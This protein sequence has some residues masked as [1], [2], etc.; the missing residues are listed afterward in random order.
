MK[1]RILILGAGFGGLAAATSLRSRLGPEHEIVVVDRKQS[2][3]MGL[4]KLWVLTGER[5]LE[6]G[7]R[8]RALLAKKDVKFVKTEAKRIDL[9]GRS[10]LT[11]AGSFSYDYLVVA[12]GAELAPELLPGF[13]EGAL[14][15]YDP[16]Q[17][18]KTSLELSGL[19]SGRLVILVCGMP[20]K[21]PPAPYEASMLIDDMLRKR[22]VRNSVQLDL[23]SAEPMPVPIAGKANSAKLQGW[24]AERGIGLN[25]NHKP[26]RIEPRSKEIVFE[27]G[28]RTKYDILLAV[29][30]HRCPKAVADAGLID[31]SGWVPVEPR[32]L[33]TRHDRVFAVGDVTIVKLPNGMMLPK[34]GIFA[35]AE[36][37]VVAEEIAGEL[38]GELSLAG[39]DGRGFCF[40]ESGGG[41]AS[42]VRG[43]FFASPTPKLE[44]G[45]PSPDWLREKH[46]FEKVRLE[47]W[48]GA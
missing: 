25:V 31:S 1:S 48:F 6:E 27:N 21:C 33:K 32:T 14:N 18:L 44:I 7:R 39:F 38:G 29:P 46:D 10:V 23:Y 45:E 24:L 47:R 16:D 2:F 13:H 9:E 11:D 40:V 19:T 35:E 42:V 12:L 41:K 43:E 3:M 22:G 28:E 15:L 20:F 36:A 8:D 26:A 4:A 30:P 34:A 5:T 17:V 37:N